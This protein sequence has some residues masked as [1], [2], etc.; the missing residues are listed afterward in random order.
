MHFCTINVL[1]KYYTNLKQAFKII[2]RNFINRKNI[3]MF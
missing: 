1:Q 3:I 2:N